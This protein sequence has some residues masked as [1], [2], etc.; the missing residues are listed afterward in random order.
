MFKIGMFVFYY[1]VG[2]LLFKVCDCGFD[3]VVVF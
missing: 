2:C 1:D 3:D